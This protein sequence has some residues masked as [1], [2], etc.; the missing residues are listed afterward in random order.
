MR[1]RHKLFD[2]AFSLALILVL[3]LVLPSALGCTSLP[4]AERTIRRSSLPV[5]LKWTFDA[6]APIRN[7]PVLTERLV[8][9]NTEALIIGVDP[10]TGKTMWNA[11]ARISDFIVPFRWHDN[12]LVFGSDVGVNV[13][14]LNIA[15]GEKM[16]SRSWQH[17]FDGQISS[18]AVDGRR[19]YVA[20]GRSAPIRAY[21][22]EDGK[23]LW[24]S[25]YFSSVP[26]NLAPR[27]NK[28]YVFSGDY[29]LHVLDA[30]TGLVKN[31]LKGEFTGEF[32]V[33]AEDNVYQTYR[34]KTECKKVETGQLCWQII[35]RY[36]F[37][38]PI[39]NRV[40][41]SSDGSA[42]GGTPTLIAI[43]KETGELAWQKKLD[44]ESISYVT[45]IGNVGYVMLHNG[46]IFGFDLSSGAEVG[47]IETSPN[48]VSWNLFGEG[49][50]T[51]GEMLFATFG[52]NKLFA[53]AK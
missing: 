42:F 38:T 6:G 52:D 40:Y 24:E 25:E 51:N 9:V 21:G 27:D 16:W 1:M 23:H 10:K 4:K 28:L 48:S 39:G 45:R 17:I 49:L 26:T 44:T 13:N 11:Q 3:W 33:F 22:L 46:A 32:K 43:D 47:R 20:R 53:F 35:G 15:T 5:S 34:N 31:F 41:A 2:T 7:P 30:E 8:L 37:F 18:V 29:W 36:R 50:D 19:V 12:V 14:V